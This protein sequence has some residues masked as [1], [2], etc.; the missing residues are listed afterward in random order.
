MTPSSEVVGDWSSEH[1]TGQFRSLASSMAG[2]V[3]PALLAGQ[4]PLV[5]R[6]REA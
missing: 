6:R 1:A 4:R 5:P 3:L 2:G